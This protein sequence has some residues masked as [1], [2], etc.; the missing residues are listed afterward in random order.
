MVIGDRDRNV[1]LDLNLDR[2]NLF[3]ARILLDLLFPDRDPFIH[4]L[5][6]CK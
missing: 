5:Q 2:F 1:E 3:V 6:R 4:L